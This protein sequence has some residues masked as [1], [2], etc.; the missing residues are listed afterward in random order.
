M[1]KA[2]C[3]ECKNITNLHAP[4]ELGQQVICQYCQA[5]LEIIWLYPLSLEA[6]EPQNDEGISDDP[7]SHGNCYGWSPGLN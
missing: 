7:P 4:L 5:I 3:P 6:A 1:I 2:I